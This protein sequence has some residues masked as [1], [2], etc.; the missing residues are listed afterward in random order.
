MKIKSV[1]SVK[2]NY[3]LSWSCNYQGELKRGT[4]KEE[5]FVSNFEDNSDITLA[6]AHLELI[7]MEKQLHQGTKE[8]STIW[9]E[10][11]N[12]VVNNR[13]KLWLLTI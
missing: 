12:R 13:S 10:G 8:S 6:D 4:Y 3:L 7:G 9:E 5:S 2:G 11:K 1:N